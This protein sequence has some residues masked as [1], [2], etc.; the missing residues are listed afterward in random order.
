[1]EITR[2]GPV[3]GAEVHGVDLAHDLSDEDFTAIRA[4]LVE[5]EVLVLRDQDITP[6]QQIAFGRRFGDLLVS[7]FSPNA[8]DNPELVVLDNHSANPPALT[9]VWHADETYRSAPPMATI[10]RANIL[11]AL[12]GGTMFASMRAAYDL[13]SD[14]MKDLIRGL[15]ALHDFGRFDGLFPGTPEARR[16]LHEIELAYPHPDHPVVRIHPESGKPVIYVN[17]H[18]TKRINELPED[19]G[20]AVL[21]LLLSRASVPEVQLRVQWQKHTM[22]MWDNRSVQH[23]ALHDYYPQ[24][25]RMERVTIA[26]D[27]PRGDAEAPTFV[28]RHIEVRDV[29]AQP[30]GEAPPPAKVARQFERTY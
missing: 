6:A 11:P 29:P 27:V 20:R 14:R 4:A 17:A 12:G 16:R 22:V 18:F 23:Y 15:T 5:H 28:P 9:D 21:D 8:D 7:P 24:R 2:I 3:F 30:D 13:L 26:G 25:R 1:M 10:L 19:E